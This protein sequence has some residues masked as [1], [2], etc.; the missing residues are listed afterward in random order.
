[1]KKSK[2]KDK[3]AVNEKAKTHFRKIIK[4][5]VFICIAFIIAFVALL[6]IDK[7]VVSKIFI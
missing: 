7:L 1:M 5:L 4:I 2:S 3:K 6:A